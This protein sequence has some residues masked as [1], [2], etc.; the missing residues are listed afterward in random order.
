MSQSF[1]QGIY[2]FSNGYER[3][4]AGGGG[5]PG[6]ENPGPSPPP[7]FDAGG[8]LTE[9]IDQIQPSYNRL[10]HK[11]QLPEELSFI[12]PQ[13]KAT[14]T[15]NLEGFH[16]I[17]PAQAPNM[18][19]PP[20]QITWIPSNGG[21]GRSDVETARAGRVLEGQGL[22][23]SLSSL[24]NLEVNN[25]FE[26]MSIGNGG[27]EVHEILRANAG[28]GELV[29]RDN[30]ARGGGPLHGAGAAGHVTAF[31][32]HEGRGGARA[33]GELRGPRG[34]GRQRRRHE[35]GDAAA[36][37]ARAEIPAAEIAAAYGNDGP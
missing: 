37:G 35:R 29:R 23:L 26:K 13:V 18:Q 31:P 28:D 9:I 34:E 32:E 1:H 19:Q 10:H 3:S 5:A 2:N 27:R 11:Q 6:F 30:G 15:S 17:S 20:S 14:P 8:M 21:G 7:V 4:T 12:N 22:S 24:R 36:E 25:K 16:L 33:E